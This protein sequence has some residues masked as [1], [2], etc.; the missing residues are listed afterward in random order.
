MTRVLFFACLIC[1]S[2][3]V[4]AQEREFGIR[5]W[6][7]NGAT[8]LSHNAQVVQPNLGNPTSVLTYD[9]LKTHAVEL[10]ARVRSRDRWFIR[11]T[12]GLGWVRKGSFDDEDFNAGQSKFSDSTSP[13]KGN[14]LYYATIDAGRD[15][16][17]FGEG[18]STVGL[19]A[20]YGH[21]VERLDAY[22]ATFSVTNRCPP[23]NPPGCADIAESVPVITNEVTWHALRLGIA[24]NARFTQRTR[25]T[26]DAA[27]V[28]YAQVRNEDSHYLR[29]SPSDLGPVPNIFMEGRGHGFQLDM[30]LRHAIQENWELGAGLRYWLLRATRGQRFTNPLSRCDVNNVCTTTTSD[31]PLTELESQR[32]GF[33]LS[34]T[35][36]W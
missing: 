35:R 30:E 22:G 17:V 26:I 18:G 33:L 27:W 5:Y 31:V 11:G 6:H 14:R 32:T 9:E 21:W 29:T 12:A 25:L 23:P 36:R 19:F 28:P 8:T 1:A 3:A 7:S 16:W 13:V 2:A 20:G 34:L 15:L 4:P 24:A 10:H